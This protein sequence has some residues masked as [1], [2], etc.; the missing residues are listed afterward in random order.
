MPGALLARIS[1]IHLD[2]KR[3]VAKNLAPHDITPQQIF[4]LRKLREA[5]SLNPSEIAAML[6]A[7][8]PTTT[9]MLGTLARRRWIIRHRDR[10]NARRVIVSLSPAGR[11]KLASVP[12]VL[13]RSGRL[14]V[15]P[16]SCFGPTERVQLQGLLDRLHAHVRACAGER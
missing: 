16:E 9:V 3:F 14:P 12:D 8:R 10:D 11:R 5:G 6:H 1:E 15:D 13:W 7:D 2:W 4:V